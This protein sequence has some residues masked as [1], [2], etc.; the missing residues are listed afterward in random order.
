MTDSDAILDD[1]LSRWHSWQRADRGVRGFNSRALMIGD[2]RA[3]K[4]QYEAQLERQDDEHD[5]LQCRQID[6]EVRQM[7]EP[8]RTAIY[9]DARNINCGIAVWSSPRLPQDPIVRQAIVVQSRAWLVRRLVSA[10]VME[11]AK[12]CLQPA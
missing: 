8:Y 3:M 7:A 10:G 12:K 4:V 5:A 6:H 9:M 11:C 1:L 2:T